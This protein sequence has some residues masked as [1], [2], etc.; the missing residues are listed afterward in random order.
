MGTDCA[1]VMKESTEVQL[2]NIST[3]LR[4]NYLAL[5][6][7]FLLVLGA[8]FL[9]SLIVIV[10]INT[11]R[12]YYALLPSSSKASAKK[13]KNA[14]A[15]EDDMQYPDEIAASGS[16]SNLQDSDN[17]RILAKINLLKTKYA[18]YN[19]ASTE[20]AN[21]H[22]TYQPNLMDEAIFSRSNDD[23]LAPQSA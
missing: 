2:S 20:Y 22:P 9:A 3:A 17:S 4:A 16:S 7:G 14:A 13:V 12:N 18:A 21:D 15:Y 8:L 10:A 23:F 6:T 11:V 1:I 19:T 5:L